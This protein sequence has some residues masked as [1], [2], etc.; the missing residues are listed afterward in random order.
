[1]KLIVIFLMQTMIVPIFLLWAL[2]KVVLGV[3]QPVG[4]I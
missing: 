4:A 1:M 2:Y 3:A